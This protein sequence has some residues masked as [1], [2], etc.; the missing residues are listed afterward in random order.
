MKPLEFCMSLVKSGDMFLKLEATFFFC[1]MK[2]FIELQ[3]RFITLW[4]RHNH[5]VH[6]RMCVFACECPA[7]LDSVGVFTPR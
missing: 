1:S 7:T 3:Y 6:M 5:S 4:K 2:L